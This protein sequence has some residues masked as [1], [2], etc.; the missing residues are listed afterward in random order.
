MLFTN[1][2]TRRTKHGLLSV[3]HGCAR[4][5]PPETVAGPSRPPASHGL[6]AH[7]FP[8]FPTISRQEIL[9]LRQSQ[10]IVSRSRWASRRAPLAGKSRKNAQNP[11]YHRKMREAQRSPRLPSPSGPLPLRLQRNEPVLRKRNGLFYVDH[12]LRGIAETVR[13]FNGFGLAARF[14]TKLP[15]TVLSEPAAFPSRIDY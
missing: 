7:H 14:P 9:P 11:A 8:Q 4:L 15:R 10:R 1:H 12:V 6:P 5:A 2:E 3:C 13:R